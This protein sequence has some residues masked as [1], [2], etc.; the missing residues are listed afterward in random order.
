MGHSARGEKRP[1]VT[2][3]LLTVSISL[4][5]FVGLVAL[6]ATAVGTAREE[7]RRS[8]CINNL[9]QI[10]L[11]LHNYLQSC[12]SFPYAAVPNN[13]LP[14]DK[15]LSWQLSV[16]P[17]MFCLHCWGLADCSNLDLSEPWH[18]GPQ[19]RLSV[20]PLEPLLCPSSPYLP[21]HGTY[22]GDHYLVRTQLT[23]KVPAAYVGIAGVGK[24][25]PAL[26]KGDRNAG[27]FGY[28]RVTGLEEIRDGTAST[29]MVSET[30]SLEAPWTSGGSATV[31][32]L[33][34]ARLPYIGRGRQFGGNHPD[35]ALI[36]FADGSVRAVRATIDPKVFENLSTI[37]GGERLASEWD[38]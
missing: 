17:G 28:D 12:G 16:L 11:G 31:R 25:A 1:F 4:G 3:R 19:S 35:Q 30:S 27:V 34:Q 8:R 38:Q 14:A 37:A 22:S 36:L 15:R 29:M 26:K 32:G 10:G 20:L 7:A 21:L 33:D 13:G 2:R 24:N 23:E 6:G 5:I 18:S 9:K